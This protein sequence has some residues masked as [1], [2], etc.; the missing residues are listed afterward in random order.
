LLLLALAVLEI[1]IAVLAFERSYRTSWM[2]LIGA[3][4]DPLGNLAGAISGALLHRGFISSVDFAI[5]LQEAFRM[6]TGLGRLLFFIGLLLYVVRRKAESTR[7]RELEEVIR[8]LEREK[9]S[10]GTEG[11]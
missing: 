11:R 4:L 9:G 1:W 8:D 7:M 10:S 2:I 5:S 3:I 6:G